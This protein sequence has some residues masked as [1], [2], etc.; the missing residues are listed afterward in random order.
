MMTHDELVPLILMV[1]GP[2]LGEA[3]VD[4]D[5][6]E[7]EVVV[8]GVVEDDVMIPNGRTIIIQNRLG[9]PTNTTLVVRP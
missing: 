2:S 4:E 9:R 5:M 7:V 3:E 8:E 1:T 6:I